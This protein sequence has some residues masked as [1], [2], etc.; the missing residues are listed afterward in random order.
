VQGGVPIHAIL[1]YI[2][3][4]PLD[5]PHT[6]L[7]LRNHCDGC[8]ARTL[9]LLAYVQQRLH[10][11]LRH[12]QRVGNAALLL[13]GQQQLLCCGAE[14]AVVLLDALTGDLQEGRQVSR[15]VHRQAG[16]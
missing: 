12:R 8:T 1:R 7:K 15:Q 2:T 16:R 14:L 13:P 5:R 10:H 9:Q 11:L 4:T 6:L 3:S